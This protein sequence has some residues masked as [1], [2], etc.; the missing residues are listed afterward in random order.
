MNHITIIA[1]VAEN[2]A[3]GRR[4]KLI[5]HLPEDM[6]RFRIL[7]TSH[8]VIMGRHTYESLPNGPLPN[9]RNIVLSRHVGQISGCDVYPSLEEALAHCQG[10]EVFIIGGESLYR[11]AMPIATRMCLTLIHALPKDADTFFP[12]YKLEEWTQVFRQDNPIDSHHEVAYS[13]VD[14]EK[15]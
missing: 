1:A 15:K 14:Y 6:K 4:G 8:T 11:E 3:I 2:L 7:T 12:M 5:Y 10:D 13:F 9:R